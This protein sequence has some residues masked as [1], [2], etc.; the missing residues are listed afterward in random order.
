ML[1]AQMAAVHNAI[2][3]FARNVFNMIEPRMSA[4][5]SRR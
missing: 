3:T 2:M 5:T 4:E 1:A